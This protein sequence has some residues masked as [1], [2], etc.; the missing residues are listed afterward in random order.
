MKD[1]LNENDYENKIID[2][3]RKKNQMLLETADEL[4]SEDDEDSL[5]EF[6]PTEFKWVTLDKQKKRAKELSN[7]TNKKK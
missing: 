7:K 4:F 3:E 1:K 6:V 2:L 5:R